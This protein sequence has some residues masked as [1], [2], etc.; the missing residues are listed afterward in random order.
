MKNSIRDPKH[1]DAQQL[2]RDTRTS[3]KIGR[4]IPPSARRLLQRIG[5][6]AEASGCEAYAVGGCVRD[7][8]MRAAKTP[9]LDVVVESNGIEF[10]TRLAATLRARLT[11]HRQFGTSTL[12]LSHGQ[13][14]DIAT[15]RKE[16]Y[17]E[18]AAY[19][20]VEPGSVRDDLFRRD[21]TINA[22]AMALSKSRFG[23]VVDPFG[24][25]R[26]LR[27]KRLRVLHTASFR[28]DPTRMLRGARFATRFG[29]TLEPS[30]R[31]WWSEAVA[32]DWLSR[33]NRG[34]VHKELLRMLEEPDSVA[35]LAWLGRRR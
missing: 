11:T 32:A 29:W 24:G 7:W 23:E 28:D 10:A 35:C 31:R 21:F 6:E 34:R 13:R 25:A 15:C 26:D 27:A 14:L 2:A 8:M 1:S 18:P 9:D 4:R 16:T 22:M 33:V 19:P 17:R 30:T 3:G 20:T 5:Q 12:R